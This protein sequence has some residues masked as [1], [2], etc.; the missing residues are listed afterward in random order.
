M[1]D[2]GSAK[3]GRG[4]PEELRFEV[5]D[6]YDEAPRRPAPKPQAP[7]RQ[8][9][10]P[11]QLITPAARP[12][13]QAAA[14]APAASDHNLDGMVFIPTEPMPAGAR[15]AKV[16]LRRMQDGRLA[17]LAYTSL[18]LLVAGCGPHQG[19]MAAPAKQLTALQPL[20]GFDVIA[21]DI[22]LPDDWRVDLAGHTEIEK[23]AAR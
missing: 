6:D 10:P 9:A 23:G 14:S 4:R 7:P 13:P 21:L 17:A 20:A 18:D 2:S 12:N 15:Q 22:E 5:E 3:R 1:P 11:A 16:Q 8:Q 19:W